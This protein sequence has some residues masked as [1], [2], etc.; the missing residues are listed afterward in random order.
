MILFKSLV[1]T[2]LLITFGHGRELSLKEALELALKNNRELKAFHREIEALK[3]EREAARGAI[4]PR[5]KIE[6]MFL[7]SDLPVNVFSFKLNQEK[8]TPDDFNIKRL[9][10]PPGRA[11]FETR[12]TIELPIWL[13]GK[14]QA[15]ARQAY[16]FL[17]AS[18]YHYHRKEEEVLWRVAQA[19]L[20]ALL[21]KESIEVAKSSIREAEEHLRI[22]K[23]RF[24]AGMALLADV[25][26]AEVYL[27]K[28]KESFE[29]AKNY[30]SLAKRNLEL[31]VGMSLGEFEVK[32][33]DKPETLSFDEIKNLALQRRKD[34]KAVEEEIK[35]Q[36]EKY[37]IVLSENLPQIS[38]FATYSLN[39]RDYPMGSSGSGYIVGLGLTWSFDLGLATIRK[40]Q[41]E[42]E[43]TSGLEIKYRFL[44][45]VI[46]FEL[47]RAYKEYEIALY[48]LQSAE[49]RVKASEEVV[50]IIK[51]RYQNGLAR[52]LDLLDAQTQLDL[53]RF[54]RVE[55]IKNLHLSR[56]QVLLA[57]GVLREF[58]L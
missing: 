43:R 57:G 34:L 7:K 56:F 31:E 26:R 20:W 47:E 24:E 19:Y 27:A 36:R 18:E 11:N 40:A 33:L 12:F 23:A 5:L 48:N 42:L 53:A 30:Y 13:G 44:K 17:R 16:Y 10:N 46:L 9:N 25:Q 6:E 8:F 21:S 1:L 52:M 41:A 55:A 51:L 29:R 3:L 22:A 32:A 15:Q 49:Q 39:H 14:L 2:L 58:H 35:A 28:A 38:A 45:D 54:E 37:R 4:F 50:R